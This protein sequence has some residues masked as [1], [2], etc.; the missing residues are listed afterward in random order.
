MKTVRTGRRKPWHWVLWHPYQGLWNWTLYRLIGRIVPFPGLRDVLQHSLI[1]ADTALLWAR[2]IF[3]RW[4]VT[5]FSAELWNPHLPADMCVLYLDLGTHR[6]AR[7]LQWVVRHVLARRTTHYRAVGFEASQTFYKEAQQNTA[8][9]PHVEMV[10]AALCYQIPRGN[11]VRLYLS[12]ADG[13]ASSLYRTSFGVYEEVP[14]IR[15]SDW[16]QDQDVD[17]TRTVLILRMNIEGAE[18]EVIRDLLETGLAE[19]V[20]GYFGMWD[21]VAKDDPEKGKAFLN[22]LNQ[23]GIRP[24]TFND[25]DFRS[26]WRMRCIAY[27]LDTAL[28]RGVRRTRGAQCNENTESSPGL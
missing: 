15:L 9:L 13:R 22:L 23:A 16:I 2:A 18:T 12:P 11:T 3:Q 24:F 26:D 28:L 21:D 7:E 19:Y 17:L 1:V 27:A 20:D 8:H 14:A 10:H 5:G 6:E 4:Q 25:R